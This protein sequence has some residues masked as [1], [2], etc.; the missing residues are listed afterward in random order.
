MLIVGS[1]KSK[2]ES[3]YA[4]F[5][6][7]GKVYDVMEG[8]FIDIVGVTGNIPFPAHSFKLIVNFDPG[9]Y[10]AHSSD[11]S[12]DLSTQKVVKLRAG[13]WNA[14]TVGALNNAFRKSSPETDGVKV[15]AT[16][17]EVDM[18][19]TVFDGDI[20]GLFANCSAVT[21]L[22]MPHLSYTGNPTSSANPN[23]LVYTPEG[24]TATV[25]RSLINIVSG[26]QALGDI[27]ID[28]AHPFNIAKPFNTGEKSARYTRSFVGAGATG[29]WQTICLPFNVSTINEANNA[30]SGNMRPVTPQQSGDFWLKEY[31]SHSGT[32][33]NFDN[34]NES[35]AHTP[36]LIAF[37]GTHRGNVFPS[38]LCGTSSGKCVESATT[39][40]P[41]QA[42]DN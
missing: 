9:Y 7:T 27:Y 21:A 1:Y 23:C 40:V 33:V 5:T 11:A 19:E 4:E 32:T 36:Y 14:T 17:Q 18:M 24:T 15:N 20:T 29:G 10:L 28:D 2:E 37:T 26:N 38:Y 25:G 30:Y 22:Y 3:C 16:L 31:V 12:K 6:K 42:Y 41:P 34:V 35:K 8:T 13:G 39:K